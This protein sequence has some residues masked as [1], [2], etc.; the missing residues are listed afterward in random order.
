MLRCCSLLF[1]KCFNSMIHTFHWHNFLNLQAI[2]TIYMFIWIVF[3]I[4]FSFFNK[5]SDNSI[6]WTM[7]LLVSKIINPFVIV[8]VMVLH[9]A[10]SQLSRKRISTYQQLHHPSSFKRKTWRSVTGE[11]TRDVENAINFNSA[12]FTLIMLPRWALLYW[13]RYYDHVWCWLLYT[14]K[15]RPKEY[16]LRFLTSTFKRKITFFRCS[17]CY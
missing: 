17:Y 6:T 9:L 2:V 11:K 3:C 7:P 16:K 1:K 4:S 10:P 14:V 5:Q 8:T 12:K 15:I 13:E